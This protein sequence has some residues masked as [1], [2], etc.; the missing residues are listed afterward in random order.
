MRV[1]WVDFLRIISAIAVIVVHTTTSYFATLDPS[2]ALWWFANFLMSFGKS[3]GTACFVML[4]GYVLLSKEINYRDFY[5]SRAKRLLIPLIFWSLFYSCFVYVFIDPSIKDFFWR[6][7]IGMLLSGEAYFHLWYL[8]M[9]ISLMVLT[10]LLN[11]WIHGTKPN[12]EDLKVIVV[13]FSV[14]FALSSLSN[15]KK[16]LTNGGIEW[17]KS[18]G[19]YIVYFVLGHLIATHIKSIKIST[20]HL[21]IAYGA[22]ILTTVTLNYFLAASGTRNDN[23][24]I[25]ND[26][27]LGFIGTLLFFTIVAK[28]K[29]GEQ[30][31][32]SLC[33]AAANGFG[34]YLV[35]PFVLF[36][37]FKLTYILTNNPTISILLAIV[38]TTIISFV[39]TATIRKTTFG[40]LIT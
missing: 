10:P 18:F 11:K 12:F 17:F 7:S 33:K 28:I 22:V 27:L 24:I 8:S 37:I 5:R 20:Q 36:F 15:I 29:P 19:I 31:K 40:R 25:G 30:I 23:A 9:F 39:L 2:A 32:D 16:I 35:H 26:T 21:L 4:A 14:F 13:I 1:H 3:M 34:V 6:I 38:F